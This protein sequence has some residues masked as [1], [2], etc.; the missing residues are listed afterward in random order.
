MDFG[1]LDLRHLRLVR[2]VVEEGSLTAAAARLALS[3]PAL[4][5][6]LVG[7]EGRLGVDLFERRGRSLVLTEAGARVLASAGVVLAEVERAEADL[8]ALAAGL[9]GT[10]RVATECFTTYHWLPDVVAELRRG[11]PGVAVELAASVSERLGEALAARAIDVGLVTLVDGLPDGLALTPLFDDEVVAVVPEGHPWSERPFVAAADF[12]SEH[13]FVYKTGG[14]RDPVL[15]GVL[16]PAGDLILI[17]PNR[18]GLWTNFETTQFGMGR[19]FG[20]SELTRALD[21]GGFVPRHWKTALVA[22]PVRGLRWLDAPLTRLFPRLGGIHFVLARKGGPPA[23]A[24]VSRRVR[25]PRPAAAP[26]GAASALR[27]P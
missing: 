1:A 13:L 15:A 5:H 18:A 23:A 27:A 14:G 11:Y 16:A 20:R 4:S 3:Q 24:P 9:A 19:P 8:A 7:V 10:R 25:A 2:A 17:V 26:A 12:A 6:Q 22:P 21:D